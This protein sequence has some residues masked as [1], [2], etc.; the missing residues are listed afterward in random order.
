M[1]TFCQSKVPECR[2]RVAYLTINIMYKIYHGEVPSYIC[3]MA[4]VHHNH[5]T[6]NRNRTFVVPQVKTH[7]SKS[8][9]LNGI[10]CWNDQPCNIRETN[11]KEDFKFKC[12]KHLSKQMKSEAKSVFTV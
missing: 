9:K 5:A 3:S 6:R 8:F 1:L 11:S 4:C 12:K 7:S 10:K 2:K